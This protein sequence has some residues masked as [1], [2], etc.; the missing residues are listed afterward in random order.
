L[1]ADVRVG[2][3]SGAMTIRMVDL[4]AEA[5]VEVHRLARARSMVRAG[6]EHALA[7]LE[8]DA[9]WIARSRRARRALGCRI[10]LVWRAAFED[11]SGLAIES[12]LVPCVLDVGGDVEI[13]SLLQQIEDPVRARVGVEGEAWQREVAR[14]AG[15]FTAARLARE[16]DIA[17]SQRL[18]SRPAVQA[19]L[20][21]R[22]A[23]RDHQDRAAA[24][25]DWALAVRDRLP[26]AAGGG[27]V[28][29]PPRLLLVLVP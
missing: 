15:A 22:R 3:W 11:A 21:D 16:Q 14:V 28:P 4:R 26:L 9:A 18:A 29:A 6:D 19:G 27:I 20:F 24:V 8:A 2:P 5:A 13:R 12:H 25:E 17:A 10:C 7:Q 23:E 1:S